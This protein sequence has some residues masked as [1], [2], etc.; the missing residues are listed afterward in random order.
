MKPRIVVFSVA[1]SV[2]AF[3]TVHAQW[4]R[5]NPNVYLTVST[6]KV[7]IGTSTP[8]TKFHVLGSGT[9]S[10]IA[11]LRVAS[12][13]E[14]AGISFLSDNAGEALIY[15]P[16]NTDELRF[17]T[18]GVDRIN[19]TDGGNVGIGTLA[20]S[21]QVSVEH[22]HRYCEEFEYR[23]NTRSM[24]DAERFRSVLKQLDGRLTYDALTQSE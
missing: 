3:H 13:N 22:L 21:H 8:A 6:D 1:V 14:Q 11:R 5:T 12:T 18:N 9:G 19:I 15:S 10:D 20:L 16:K 23:Y 4:S 7:G 17:Q 2:L 24:K